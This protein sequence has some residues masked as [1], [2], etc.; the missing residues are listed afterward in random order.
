MKRTL[1]ASLMLLST[2][3]AADEFDITM[4]II[5]A[6]ESIDEAIVNRIALPFAMSRTAVVPG[7]RPGLEASSAERPLEA[8]VES[9]LDASEFEQGSGMP[10]M[11]ELGSD[12]LSYGSHAVTLVPE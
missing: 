2:V 8:L 10:D 9:Q 6:D 12:G 11:Q 1:L 5:G 4:E 3:A 7:S